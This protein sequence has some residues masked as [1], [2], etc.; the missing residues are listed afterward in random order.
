MLN[1]SQS[2]P[3]VQSLW[4]HKSY[5]PLGISWQGH[6]ADW[7]YPPE[8]V[9]VY[10]FNTNLH[11]WGA[12]RGQCLRDQKPPLTYPPDFLMSLCSKGVF[13]CVC[14]NP[15]EDTSKCYHNLPVNHSQIIQF[16]CKKSLFGVSICN[17]GDTALHFIWIWHH[18]TAKVQCQKGRI[19]FLLS[20]QWQNF[21]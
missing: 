20:L 12:G 21:H 16:L 13:V 1:W 3:G 6:C 19:N 18:A 14:M 8:S 4:K 17:H 7:C 9:S 2:S 15:I 10:R 11:F 5:I